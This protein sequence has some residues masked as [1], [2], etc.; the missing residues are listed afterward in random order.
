MARDLFHG[1]DVDLIPGTLR[2]Y[3]EWR[4][5]RLELRSLFH[6]LPW[7]SGLQAARCAGYSDDVS[8]R[9]RRDDGRIPGSTCSCGFYA[10]YEMPRAFPGYTV[11]G[12][13]QA[14]G[15]VVLGTQGFRA[16]KARIEAL[17]APWL[18]RPAHLARALKYG[19]PVFASRQRFL[20]KYPPSDISELI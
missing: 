19:V 20:R 11:W 5:A 7:T 3:R 13:I 1:P 14:Q 18:T 2:G 6:D 12:V 9:C 4:P 10:H 17:Y 15:R 16:E 8:G